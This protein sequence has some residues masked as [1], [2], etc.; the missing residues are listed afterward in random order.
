MV[1]NKKMQKTL[2]E[3]RELCNQYGYRCYERFGEIHI[4]TKFEAWFFVPRNDGLLKLMHG[5]TLGQCPNR[6]HKQFMR[7]MSYREM[8]IYIHEHEQSKYTQNVP[9]FFTFTKNG[10]R[11]KDVNYCF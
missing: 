5:N 6:Y 10:A 7:R 2:K 8:F 3:I 1:E 4:I 11:K 9:D